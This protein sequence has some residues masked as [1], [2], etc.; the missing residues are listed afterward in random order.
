MY[1]LILI[2]IVLSQ[3][4]KTI[5][6]TLTAGKMANRESSASLKAW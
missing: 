2:D 4:T 5:F 6:T 1:L 3:D